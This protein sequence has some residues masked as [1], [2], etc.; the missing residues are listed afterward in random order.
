MFYLNFINMSYAL[1]LNKNDKTIHVS[2]VADF[3]RKN[4]NIDPESVA[5]ELEQVRDSI[6][7]ASPEQ[8]HVRD[9]QASY[10]LLTD[11]IIMFREM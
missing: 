7:M 5:L 2:A 1:V 9:I 3:F 8:C 6:I 10:K 4:P 11:L